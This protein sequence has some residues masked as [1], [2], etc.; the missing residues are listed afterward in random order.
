MAFID[1]SADVLTRMKQVEEQALEKIGLQCVSHAKKNL[2]ESIP[3]NSGAWTVGGSSVRTTTGALRNSMSHLVKM[4]EHCVYV[5][6]NMRYAKYNEYGTGVYADGGTGKQGFWVFVPGKE[7]SSESVGSAKV[8]TE[9]EA[10][11]IVAMLQSKGV[12]AHM[13][14]GMKPIHFLKRAVEEHTKEYHDMIMDSFQ[15][16]F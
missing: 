3:R 1:R 10:R 12:D 15:K 6:T 11:R 7:G 14:N 13:T 5:G 4:D 16:A 8:Y 9:A 2:T